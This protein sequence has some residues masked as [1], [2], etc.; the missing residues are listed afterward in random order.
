MIT[1]CAVFFR[2]RVWSRS[3]RRNPLDRDVGGSIPHMD[4]FNAYQRRQILI[5]FSFQ[6]LL[7]NL[8]NEIQNP[9][10]KILSKFILLVPIPFDEVGVRISSVKLFQL[11]GGPNSGRP[12]SI[13]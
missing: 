2:Q 10:I 6:T 3:L 8:I 11:L 13:A 4:K 12:L 9:F 1:I 5:S 7:H